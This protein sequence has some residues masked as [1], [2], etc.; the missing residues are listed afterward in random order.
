MALIECS[1]ISKEFKIYKREKGFLKA[2]ASMFHR[3]YEIKKAIEDISFNIDEGEVVGYLGSN[4][5]GKSTTLKILSGIL[6]PS[7]GT[8]KV[9]G[10]IPYHQRKKNAMNIGAVFGQRTQLNWDLPVIDSYNLYRYMY[11]I[12]PN[13]FKENLNYFIELMEMGS[14]CNKPVR[15][16]SLGQ[17]M[18]A[19]LVGA[20]LHDPVILYLDEPTIGLDVVAKDTMRKFIKQISVEKNTTV[21]LTTHDIADVEAVC[22]RIILIDKGQKIYDGQTEAFKKDL[23]GRDEL[24]IEF[25]SDNFNVEHS[26][27]DIIRKEGRV[28]TFGFSADEISVATIISAVAADNQIVDIQIKPCGI[29]DV[30][31]LVY[32]E[33]AMPLFTDSGETP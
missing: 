1:N 16:L 4:G 24:T 23:G 12:N 14:F 28:V 20:L 26:I 33:A 9:K 29:E 13:K 27:A 31:K 5:A 25:A 8:A 10:L 30:L 7:H 2:V 22:N 18:R 6:T 19:E 32:K 3:D 17:K 21:I 15:Q 11:D